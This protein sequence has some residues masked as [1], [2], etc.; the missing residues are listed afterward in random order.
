MLFVEVFSV[1]K[2]RHRKVRQI[3]SIDD[4]V[5]ES[6]TLLEFRFDQVLEYLLGPFRR[7]LSD[8]L[9]H[10]SP[11]GSNLSVRYEVHVFLSA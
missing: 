9:R 3:T 5:F 1:F 11:L 2:T 4:L 7:K 10:T 8:T 6:V